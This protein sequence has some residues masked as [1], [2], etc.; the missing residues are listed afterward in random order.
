MQEWSIRHPSGTRVNCPKCGN[1]HEFRYIV[2]QVAEDHCECFVTCEC[3]YDPD[4]GDHIED[5]W[6]STDQGMIVSALKMWVELVEH[7]QKES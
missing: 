4:P 5:V 2:A 6:G 1:N 3:G 7:Q